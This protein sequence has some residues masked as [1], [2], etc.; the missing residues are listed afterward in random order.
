MSYQKKNTATSSIDCHA[1]SVAPLDY[2]FLSLTCCSEAVDD[3]P[4]NNSPRKTKAQ[5][6]SKKKILEKDGE[7]EEKPKSK[8]H[9]I[10]LN[11]NSIGDLGTLLTTVET[12][13]ENPEGVYLVD[14]SFNEVATVDHLLHLP[15]LRSLYLHSNNITDLKEVDKL[16]TLKHLTKLTLHGNPI[17]SIKD[18]RCYVLAKL[19][20]LKQF[21]F[22]QITTKD[23][24]TANAPAHKNINKKTKKPKTEG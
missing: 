15:Q 5:T 17:E 3:E 20:Q 19:P 24:E 2:S 1:S 14:L 7:P 13:F 12:L 8:S 4:R 21:D 16:A 10:K 6:S 9:G 11:N 18:Y 23:R 22:S